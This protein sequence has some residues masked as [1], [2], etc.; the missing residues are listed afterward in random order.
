MSVS[1]LRPRTLFGFLLLISLASDSLPVETAEPA[2]PPKPSP[3]SP[4]DELATFRLFPGLRMELVAAEPLIESPVA[5]AFD[6]N[7][8]LWV[9]EMLDYPNGPAKG[10]PPQGRIKVL[11]DRD[12]DG[13]YESGSVFADRLLFANGLLPWRGGAIVTAAPHILYLRDTDGDGK[14]DQRDVLFEGFAEANPQLRVNHPVLGLDNWIYVANGLRGGK[15]VR[16]GKS[17]P[18]ISLSN[19]DFR[20]DLIRD[21]YEAISGMGQFGNTFDDWGNRFVC[22][23]RH[24]LRHIVL[25]NHYIKRNPYLAVKQVV[26]DPSE[27]KDGPLSSG[28]RIYPISNNWTTS[29]LHAGHFTAA[30]GVHIYRGDLLPKEFYGNAYTCD[31]TNDLVHREILQPTGGSFRSRPDRQGIEFLASTDKWFRPVYLADG[32]DGA[33]YVVDMYR[34]VIEHPEFM[35]TELKNRPDL[36]LG[37]E[38]GRIWRIVPE[39]HTGKPFACASGLWGSAHKPDAPA[40]GRPSTPELVALLEHPNAWQRTTAQRLLLERQ[41]K[42]GIAPLRRLCETSKHA[43]ARVHAAWL[44]EHAEAL[45]SELLNRL[46]RDEQARVREQAVIL[47]ERGLANTPEFQAQFV[48]LAEDSDARVRFQVALS[49]GGWDDPEET[50]ALTAIAVAG[51]DDS[52]TRAAIASSAGTRAAELL[53]AIVLPAGSKL[54]ARDTPGRL[55]LVRELTA[56][57]GARQDVDEVWRVL[58]YVGKNTVKDSDHWQ[59]AAL[60]GLAE[61]IG[62]RGG[63]LADFLRKTPAAQKRTDQSVED[64]FGK[65]VKIAQDDARPNAERVTAIRLLAHLPWETAETPLRQLLTGDVSQ[66]TRLAAIAALAAQQRPEVAALLMKNWRGYS[67]AVRREVTEAML[68][69]P[70][71]I[72]SLLDELEGGRVKPGDLDATRVQQLVNNKNPEIRDRSRKLL[73]DNLPAERKQVL[74]RYQGALALSGNSDRGKAV[75]Q[76]NCA[77]CHQIAGIGIRVGPDIS[78]TRVKTREALLADILNPNQAIDNNYVNYIVSTKSGKI[79]SGMIAVETASSITLQRAENQTDV[80]LRQD[81][82]EIQSTGVSLMPDGLEKNI[83]VE[84]MADLLAFLKNWRYLD[85]AVPVGHR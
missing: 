68:R 5:M 32:P 85:G 70:A 42:A 63:R 57:V 7:G 41:D 71:R 83:S 39:K 46:L 29:N 12:G 55:A 34:A 30:C 58:V 76:K 67:P 2:T 84:E 16:S 50:S 28:G 66:E 17:E 11:E 65:A 38:R 75:F 78:D 1:L 27:L 62:R 79:L 74:D 48:R 72:Q 69:Q 33:L 56:L 14:A 77:T 31:P 61:G 13:R 73:R 52:W 3:L 19:M 40:K 64:L 8:K 23:N 45:D 20:F 54:R 81:I 21:R 26:E 10:Q 18:P 15:I 60:A 51:W 22:D 9:V 35:P 82:E 25:Q 80:V 47:A 59:L 36:T 44:L 37:K 6:E 24:H 4:A 49:L 53:S 43:T